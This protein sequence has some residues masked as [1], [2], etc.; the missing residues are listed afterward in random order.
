MMTLPAL[1]LAVTLSNRSRPL[2]RPEKNNHSRLK[3]LSRPIE[4]YQQKTI[5]TAAILKDFGQQ[6]AE[7]LAII[8]R[9]LSTHVR[10]GQATSAR[11]LLGKFDFYLI[12]FSCFKCNQPSQ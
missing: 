8:E 11:E 2:D 12:L 9:H 3:S 1:V 4:Q 5:L 6:K 7:E 10:Q